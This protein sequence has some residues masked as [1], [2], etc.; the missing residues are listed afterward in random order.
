VE[1]S[2]SNSVNGAP[3]RKAV[4]TLR[5][6]DYHSA[7]QALTD[8]AGHFRFDDVPAGHY[9]V[10]AEA[11]GFVRD[12]RAY[13]A[14]RRVVVAAEQR[15]RDLTVRLTPLATISG[16]VLDENGGAVSGADVYAVRQRFR[17]TGKDF[18]N[19]EAAITNNRG[20]YRLFDVEPG[21]WLLKFRKSLTPSAATGQVHGALPEVD[22]PASHHPGVR[23]GAE[24][25]T[26][27]VAPG[28]QL[29][30]IDLHLRKV[31]VFHVRG[32]VVGPTPARIHDLD[33]RWSVQVKPDGTFD[34]A[35]FSSGRYR[36]GG[37]AGGALS[38]VQEV[39]VEGRDVDG[40][41]F[42]IEPAPGGT[43]S[44]WPELARAAT[45]GKDGRFEF[46]DLAP[47]RLQAVRVGGRRARRA[48]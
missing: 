12:P 16:K 3:V 40:L 10:S 7:Y 2:V 20:E 37:E 35:G 6:A 17:S 48:A 1:G 19:G 18:T 47:G 4:V 44:V 13:I 30:G 38:T 27:F 11:P 33:D 23:T 39:T 8:A 41:I 24:A 29:T 21:P 31:R 9:Q 34:I 14:S 5:T 28:A 26:L 36:L 15:V 45:A 46:R 32:K 42:R 25:E 22:Y 43:G